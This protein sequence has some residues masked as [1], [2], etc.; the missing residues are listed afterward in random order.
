MK[1]SLN[2][3]ADICGTKRRILENLPIRWLLT[4]S[5]SLSFPEESLFFALKTSRNDGHRYIGELYKRGLRNFVVSDGKLDL[6]LYPEANIVWVTDTLVALQKLAAFHRQRFNCP[7]I[8]ITG[9]N[10]KTIVKEWLW[11]VLKDDVVI[12]RSPRS[13]N[14][15]I[16]VPLSVWQMN[17]TTELA[18]LEAGISEPGEM[19]HLQEII[20]P[21][22]GLLTNILAAHQ[23]NFHSLEEKAAEKVKLFAGCKTIVY[24]KDQVVS[25]QA[26]MEAFQEDRLFGWSCMDQSAPLYIRQVPENG[27]RTL[28]YYTYKEHERSFILPFSDAPSIENAL[29]CLAIMVLRGLQAPLIAVRM[30]ALEPVAMRLEVKEGKN[31]CVVIND[32]YNA[33]VNALELALDFQSRR[34]AGAGM[35]RTLILSDILQSGQKADE[36]YCS[37]AE[38]LQRKKVDH[39]I[40]VGYEL[41]A[42]AHLFPMESQFYL[43]TDRLLLSGQ[44]DQLRNESI[45]IKG[46]R[47]FGF[48]EV[49][50]RLSLK[51]HETVLEVNLDALVYNVNYFRS[52]LSP[53]TQMVCMV[54]AAGYGSG[55]LEIAK[56]LQSHAV[57]VVAVAVADEGVELRHGGIHIPILVMNP[58]FGSFATIFEHKLEPE[59]YSFKLLEAFI[60]EADREGV[61]NYP[62]HLKL[63]T[64]MHRLGFEE[65]DL[66]ELLNRLQGQESLRVRTIFSHLAGSDE[67]QFDDYTHQQLELFERLSSRIQEAFPHRILRHILNSAGIDR[68]PEYQYDMVR[69]GIGMY[70][71]SAVDESTL[72]NVSSL[73]TTILQIRELEAGQSVGYSRKGML[74]RTSRIATLPIG[75]ADG[76]DRHLGNGAGEVLI[77]GHR[78]P[79][80]GNICMD[81]CM[82]DVTDIL[83][84]E[85]DEVLIFG[86]GLTL[87]EVAGKLGT[88]PYEILT[89]VS[90]RVKR[91]YFQE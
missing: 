1:Y 42:H 14:S 20:Q 28:I 52:R 57:D 30:G 7:V 41:S 6:K 2:D 67:A 84:E 8:A 87:S 26:L 36:L 40:G 53:K 12:T 75:Y 60:R 32:S 10:G 31:G 56:T 71:I 43:Q 63:D 38:M 46:S 4:D 82:V 81:A 76:L 90:N 19:I 59:I 13:Y 37:V 89:S 47:S 29:H 49:S 73:K 69:L 18:L 50:E 61:R 66:D 80:I 74:F 54:K 44:L 15:Q 65:K 45:L 55:A 48:E 9:S 17:E 51:V 11:Q 16:G 5:R 34:T 88:I 86:D 24:C 77:H 83:A 35:K 3:I 70:G 21:T 22:I 79:F 39:L 62:I 25:E 72:R 33:D 68:F 27:L 23:E 64:G 91:I 78:A 85:G 58:E